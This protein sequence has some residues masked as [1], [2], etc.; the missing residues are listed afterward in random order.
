M[1]KSSIDWKEIIGNYY[2]S[3][4]EVQTIYSLTETDL[5]NGFTATFSL[6][7]IESRVFYAIGYACFLIQSIVEAAQVSIQAIVD[8]NYICNDAYWHDALLGFQSGD[9]LTLN[10]VTKRYQYAVTDAT[11]QIIKRVAVRENYDADDSDKYKV[12]IY[13]AGESNGE[14][15]ALSAPQ[16]AEVEAYVS[17]IKYAGVLTKLVSGDGDT[18]DIALTVNY[19]PLL[20]NTDGELIND[21][22]KP[23]DLAAENYI[24]VLNTDYFKGNLNVTRFIDSIQSATGVVDVKITGLSINAVAKT[25]LWGTYESTN[26]WFKIGTLTVTYQ[27]QTS[28]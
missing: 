21:G 7:S 20:L 15:I 16:K 22:S 24:K 11:K 4:P 2:I 8:K 12:F 18:L 28:I 9:D 13:V 5:Q 26:G 27:P 23:V 1:A 14:I 3:L 10:S 25:E 17:K 19:N 6:A